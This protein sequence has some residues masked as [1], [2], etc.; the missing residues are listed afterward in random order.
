MLALHKQLAAEQH[1]QARSV[2]Q[3]QTAATDQEI[4]ALV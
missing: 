3:R 1:P 2:M 4:D